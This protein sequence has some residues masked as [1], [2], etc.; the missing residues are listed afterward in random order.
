[1]AADD[2]ERRAP[3]QPL[4]RL[5]GVGA[6]GV[7]AVAGATGIEQ[8][9]ERTTE[10]A[11][12]RALENPAVVRA[13]SRALQ[14]GATEQLVEGALTSEADARAL[15]SEQVGDAI[16][17]A[18]DS[19]QTDRVWRHLLASD[20]VQMLVERIAEAPEV[21]A[22]ITQQGVGLLDDL[23]RGV[24]E[25]SDHVDEA[26]EAIVRRLRGREAPA[27]GPN[28]VGLVTRSVA[29]GLDGVLLNLT[30]LAVSAIF[31][32]TI[33]G[34][35]GD[36]QD[37]S[38]PAL[39]AGIGLWCITGAAYL[40]VCWALAGQT[41]GMRALSIRLES[42]VGPK[43][44]FRRAFRR[45]VGTVLSVFTLGVGF[46][47]VIFDPG[48]RSLADRFAGTTVIEEEFERLAPH[49]RDHAEAGSP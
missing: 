22:A 48:R 29:A 30:F 27:P 12:I 26:L 28:R 19:E 40:S 42:P 9:A 3:Q 18:L 34:V 43:I 2:D 21:R 39:V 10:E 38:A 41:V 13:I 25:L 24:R 4:P 23:G 1:M 14:T 49:T 37:P 46:L 36:N 32:V 6:R 45:L 20:E 44:G 31:G 17:R 33:G 7:R 47:L 15:T 11:V 16:I 35:L 8:A 5:I